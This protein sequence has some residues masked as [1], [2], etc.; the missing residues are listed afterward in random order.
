MITLL[1]PQLAAL[2]LQ[3]TGNKQ[4]GQQIHRQKPD[5]PEVHDD[6]QRQRL[7]LFAPD[8]VRQQGHDGSELGLDCGPLAEAHSDQDFRQPIRDFFQIRIR[9]IG[10]F[11]RAKAAWAGRGRRRGRTRRF[12]G[13]SRT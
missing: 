1:T 6:A 4:S 9:L 13:G 5:G 7:C 2:R 10:R 11:G 12:A 8:A 3:R